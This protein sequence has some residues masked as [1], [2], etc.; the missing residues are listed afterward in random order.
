MEKGKGENRTRVALFCLFPF[1]FSLFLFSGCGSPGDPRPPRPVVPAAI[2]DLEGHQAGARV[3]LTFTLPERTA[4]GD[5]LAA[6]PDI[7]LYRGFTA[8]GAPPPVPQQLALTI[9]SALVDTYLTDGR[10]RFEDPVKPEDVAAHRD[11]VWVYAVR[12]RVAGAKPGAHS[13]A[14]N[15]IAVRVLPTPPAPA[16]VAADSTEGAVALQWSAVNDAVAYRVFRAEEVAAA[17]GAGSDAR[18]AQPIL[19]GSTPTT[20]FRD[21][22]AEFSKTYSYTVRAV[23]Q[24]ENQ[25]IESDAS[26]PVRVERRDTFAPAT[27]SNIV[28]IATPATADSPAALDLSWSISAEPDAA[29]YFIY[30]SEQVGTPGTRITPEMLLAPAFRDTSVAPGRRY[31][32]SVSAVDRQGNESPRSAPVSEVVPEK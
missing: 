24:I 25:S 22:Q 17:P 6:P 13:Q 1:L 27:P 26:A 18:A 10:V 9:P 23:A 2:G 5:A 19:L 16:N 30:R 32:Y 31:Y 28:I 3:A 15:V 20:G 12:T 14:S 8:R 21:T 4:D 29:G 7:E 11:D